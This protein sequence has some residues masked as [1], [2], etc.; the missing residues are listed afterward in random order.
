MDYLNLIVENGLRMDFIAKKLGISRQNLYQ[1][2]HK[3]RKFKP[4][5]EKKLQEILKIKE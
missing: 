5:E 1:K 3:Q 2:L 4:D